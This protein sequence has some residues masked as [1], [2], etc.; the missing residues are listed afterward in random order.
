MATDVD[1]A[2]V[3]GAVSQQLPNAHE[4]NLVARVASSSLIGSKV[5]IIDPLLMFG[6]DSNEPFQ[7]NYPAVR[8][9]SIGFD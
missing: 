8:S 9:L 1:L 7:S 6:P 3:I 2:G 5:V 4:G